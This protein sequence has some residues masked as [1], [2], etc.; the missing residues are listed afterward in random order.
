MADWDADGPGLLANLTV[1]LKSE[2]DRAAARRPLS[3]AD[4]LLW[5]SLLLAGLTVPD[6]AYVGRFRGDAGLADCHVEV[7]DRPGVPPGE[8]ADT[9]DAFDV[10]LRAALDVLDALIPVGADLTE[11]DLNAVLDLC[12]WAHAE[13]VRIHPF[14]NGNG[15]TARLWANVL[16]MRYGVPPF[17]ALRPRPDGGYEAAAAAAMG[18]DWRPT[19][20]VFRGMLYD[21]L[22]R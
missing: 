6:P 8:V 13:W 15:R 2:R 7:G 1:I 3:S 19:A 16:A 10:R 18:G 17:V 14:A 22:I 9:L 5:Q 12:A 21:A 11:D 20:A 4:A